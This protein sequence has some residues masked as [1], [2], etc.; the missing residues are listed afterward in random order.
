M[1]LRGSSQY[2]GTNV[3][4]GLS[5]SD[6]P[7]MVTIKDWMRRTRRCPSLPGMLVVENMSWLFGG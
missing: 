1:D 5:R 4:G 2:A 3:V 6:V 7:F